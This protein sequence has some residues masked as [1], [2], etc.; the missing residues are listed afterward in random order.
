MNIET[1]WYNG[2]L[3]SIFWR[4]F[5]LEKAEI[6]LSKENSRG[7][8]KSDRDLGPSL[9]NRMTSSD[10]SSN[11]FIHRTYKCICYWDE[12]L[13]RIRPGSESRTHVY[14]LER[15]RGAFKHGWSATK[16]LRARNICYLKKTQSYCVSHIRDIHIEQL[17]SWIHII[18]AETF[19]SIKISKNYIRRNLKYRNVIIFYIRQNVN[20]VSR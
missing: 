1:R 3:F 6:S 17:K 20:H 5:K 13:S 11:L 4:L 7:I 10:L 18:A 16:P 12:P 14:S 15:A 2:A 8:I 19:E 9:S